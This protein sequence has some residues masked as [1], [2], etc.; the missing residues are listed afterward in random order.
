MFENERTANEQVIKKYKEDVIL[1]ARYLPWLESKQGMNVVSHYTPESATEG[2]M[3][4]PTYD[5][6]LL[7]FIK[8]AEQTNFMERNYDYVYRRYFMSTYDDELRMIGRAQ[9]QDMDVL[10]AILSKYV[11]KGR[12]KGMIWKDGVEQGIFYAVVSKMKELIEFWDVP[13]TPGRRL[14]E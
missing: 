14:E 9:I 12:V 4:I 2:T 5:S 8:C 13:F 3:R 10:G 1:L 11:M 7:S 6:T